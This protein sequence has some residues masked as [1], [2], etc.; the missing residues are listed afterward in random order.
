MN[1]GNAP[2]EL[3]KLLTDLANMAKGMMEENQQSSFQQELERLFP[4][5][6]GTRRGA[7]SRELHRVG[8]GE[9]FASTATDPNTSFATPS[10]AEGVIEEI[11]GS[12]TCGDSWISP[13]FKQIYHF[14]I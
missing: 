11:K 12:K 14:S 7:K 4:S 8:A 1:S 9:S 3:A 5:T 2:K 6:T 10:I 13:C